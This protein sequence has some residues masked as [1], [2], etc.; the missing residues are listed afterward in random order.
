[1]R[2][3]IAMLVCVFA[4][5]LMANAAA[6]PSA[7]EREPDQL[8]YLFFASDKPVL[9]RLHVRVG[10]RAYDALWYDWMTKLFAWFDKDNN[11]TLDAKEIVRVPE[12]NYLSNNLQGGIGGAPSG[13]ITLATFDTNKDGKVDKKE[14]R[15]YYRRS[16]NPLRFFMNNGPATSAKQINESIYK[17]LDKPA[18]GPLTSTDMARLPG[19]L[20]TLDENE[21]EMLSSS[22][23]STGNSDPYR[24]AAAQPFGRLKLPVQTIDTG[25]MALQDGPPLADRL[26]MLTR[27]YDENKDG[28]LSA[29]EIGLDRELFEKL[30]T[31][32]D[33]NLDAKELQGF[34][35]R[36]PDLVFRIRTGQLT[37]ATGILAKIGLGKAVV[38]DRLE[39]NPDKATMPMAKSV[40]KTNG[41][42]LAFSLGDTRFQV[43]AMDS[44]NNRY[45]RL[46]GVRSFYVQQFNTLAGEKGYVDK[47]QQKDGNDP[48]IFP[49]FPQADKDANDK[50]T[51]KEFNEWLDMLQEGGNVHVSIQVTDQGRSLFSVLDTNGDGNLSMREMRSAWERMKPLC[52]TDKG[53]LVAD[54]PR[55][56]QMVVGHGDAYFSGGFIAA[57][58]GY[59]MTATPAMYRG[60]APAWF[61]KMDR[62]GDGD[63]SPREWLG[64]EEE[65][66][67]MDTD[68]DGLISAAE[69]NAYEKKSP[70]K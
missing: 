15:E 36:T 58:T 37:T 12:A 28:K 70:K 17:R 65:F 25:V 34:F 20:T 64:T 2:P 1:M 54:L 40:K 46:S 49:M 10:D 18:T 66:A 68:K 32:K 33:G 5:V 56:M 3:F 6:P 43:Q 69:A 48:Y 61:T 27:R 50:L 57:P 8:D 19:M 38:A 55:T 31:N 13:A 42:N 21:D 35:K 14:F 53:F 60:P 62:N 26:A 22:E 23:L 39:I 45:N 4:L 16:V 44:G 30:D 52:K 9:I 24:R 41:Q 51:K 47:S 11:G 59:G 29:K 7:P 63:L 67:A